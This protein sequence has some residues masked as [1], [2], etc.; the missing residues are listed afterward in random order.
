MRMKIAE[1]Q[2][3]EAEARAVFSAS[4]FAVLSMVDSDGAPYAVPIHPVL[5]G[6]CVYFHS[7]R[8]G[9]K[10]DCLYAAPQVCLTAVGELAIDPETRTGRYASAIVFGTAE[11]LTVEADR[12]EA[13]KAICRRYAPENTRGFDTG[14]SNCAPETALW[15]ITITSITGK[16]NRK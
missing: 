16:A 3:S 6:D 7:A 13:L 14:F 10:N 4:D 8:A 9:F 15:K 2:L 12:V 5:V 1:R 11:E